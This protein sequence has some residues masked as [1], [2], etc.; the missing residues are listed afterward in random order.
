MGG[1]LVPMTAGVALVDVTAVVAGVVAG[2]ITGGE[3]ATFVALLGAL[4]VAL[5][6]AL[7]VA[8][9]GALTTRSISIALNGRS[10]VSRSIPLPS[11]VSNIVNPSPS[12]CSASVMTCTDLSQRTSPRTLSNMASGARMTMAA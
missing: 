3:T 6:V 1:A 11:S 9:L 8:L 5:G 2:A 4:A 10:T 12:N 7:G